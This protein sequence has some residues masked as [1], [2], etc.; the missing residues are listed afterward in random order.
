MRY[1]EKY[2]NL[3]K[4]ER[5][6]TIWFL[7]LFY[8]IF[9]LYDVVYY[10]LTVYFTDPLYNGERS[11]ILVYLVLIILIPI[12]IYLIRN[13]KT[14]QVKYLLFL[15]FTSVNIISEIIFYSS[16]DVTYRSGNITE[17]VIIL[18][19]PIFVNKSFFYLV[20]LGTLAK[21]LIVGLALWEPVAILPAII[22]IILIIVA[23]I[24]LYRFIAYVRAIE[25][26][27]DNQLEGIVK[28]VI[29]TLELK[30]PYTR[31][32]SERVAGYARLLAKSAKQI[33]EEELKSFY[34]AC[35]LHDIGKVHIPDSIL[36]KKGKLTDEEFEIIKSH[37]TVGAEAVRNV[38]GIAEYI[39]VI[40][41]HHER[42]DGNGYPDR[43][44]GEQISLLTRITSVADAFDAMTSSRSYRAALPLEVAYQ[45]IIDGSGTQFDP[46]VVKLFKEIYPSWVEFH[47]KYNNKKRG[48]INENP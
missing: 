41:H 19:S 48:E 21:Y 20:S 22:T 17:I 13:E 10:Y 15:V 27:Y 33:K 18:F 14:S 45:R 2:A 7:W 6:T 24:I 31:G 1:S 34:Y 42:W 44:K 8:G 23:S 47:D 11:S 26:S 30:D 29:A 40:K 37:P 38:E 35:L 5:R 3:A 16:S 36:S 25:T 9:F 39:D 4:E 46:E 32:H 12:A 28:G 43:L